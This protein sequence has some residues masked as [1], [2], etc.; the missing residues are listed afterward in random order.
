MLSPNNLSTVMVCLAVLKAR[1]SPEWAANFFRDGVLRCIAAFRPQELANV[2]TA[3][4]G[5]EGEGE[6]G[7]PAVRGMDLATLALCVGHA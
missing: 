6:G 7:F 3:A 5:G 2:L 1:P 4:G